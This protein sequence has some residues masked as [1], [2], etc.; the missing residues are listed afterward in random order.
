VRDFNVLINKLVCLRYDDYEIVFYVGC[1][2]IKFYI[3]CRIKKIL[4]NFYKIR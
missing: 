4:L 1:D 2:K 3:E